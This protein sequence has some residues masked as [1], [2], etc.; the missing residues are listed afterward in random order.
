MGHHDDDTISALRRCKFV[1][2]SRYKNFDQKLYSSDK[3]SLNKVLMYVTE[4]PP[5]QDKNVTSVEEV[6][7]N[8]PTPDEWM[9]EGYYPVALADYS[10][11]V[12]ADI[13]KGLEPAQLPALV[14]AHLHSTFLS[15]YPDGILLLSPFPDKLN[16]LHHP[17]R[18]LAH[19]IAS[20][21]LNN[22]IPESC[23][24]NLR[25]CTP[26]KKPAAIASPDR[27]EET[28]KSF[29]LGTIPHPFV[30]I[31]LTNK[32]DISL[33]NDPEKTLLRYIRRKSV[34][35]PWIKEVTKDPYMTSELGS[36][37]RVSK[38]K[39]LVV[40]KL[41]SKF[42][43]I[44]STDK[45]GFKDIEW[46]LGFVP[47]TIAELKLQLR[48]TEEKQKKKLHNAMTAA[49]L[50]K[51]NIIGVVEAWHDGDTEVWKFVNAWRERRILE[52]AQWTY[53]EKKFGHGLD[54]GER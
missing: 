39:E 16:A 14:N 32:D 29:T 33:M 7:A 26:C 52:R 12:V 19:R 27:L 11:E 22:P 28:T 23:P 25:I 35:D 6:I 20:C 4:N 31:E 37:R 10:P 30:T 54:K 34:R 46:T 47:P 13:Y 44:W 21:P 49:V 40:P 2:M 9:Q 42:L 17:A 8:L 38:I 15:H 50:G 48:P 3:A 36:P 24:P 43:S 1:Y 5:A 45:E 41:G 18:E 53:E 51:K